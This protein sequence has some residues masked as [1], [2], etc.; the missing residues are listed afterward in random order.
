VVVAAGRD[1]QGVAAEVRRGLEAEAVHVEFAGRGHV[2]DGQ[3]HMPDDGVADR[4]MRLAVAGQ[5][6]A[7]KGVR[8][9]VEGGHLDLAVGPA[10]LGAVAV[11]VQ[12]DAVALRVGEV[13]GLA[14]QVI[15]AAGER[16]RMRRAHRVD[17]RGELRLRV[18][19][20]RGVEQAARAWL[21]GGQLRGVL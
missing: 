9:E 3:V 13:E 7:D 14:D 1:E 5:M 18:E 20:D 11:P 8:I 6:L 16:S 12:L 17:G 10:P 15:G 19:Q 21:G 4:R 2:A